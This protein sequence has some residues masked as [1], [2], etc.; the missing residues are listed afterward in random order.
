MA[1]AEVPVLRE[2]KEAK[3]ERVL[4]QQYT[5]LQGLAARLKNEKGAQVFPNVQ[6]T[7][8][9]QAKSG[10]FV[11]HWT[12]KVGEEKLDVFVQPHPRS[13]T[14]FELESIMAGIGTVT[15]DSPEVLFECLKVMQKK[16]PGLPLAPQEKEL[17]ES[18]IRGLGMGSMKDD[19]TLNIRATEIAEGIEKN[20]I[21]NLHLKEYIRWLCK[22]YPGFAE[23]IKVRRGFL[24]KNKQ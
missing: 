16:E 10:M 23:K 6:T 1:D 15:A 19:V 3:A 5:S 13:T 21:H 14:G 4:Q 11:A 22:E 9:K 12:V 2:S 17:W 8:G 18:L 7:P 20:E 24:K